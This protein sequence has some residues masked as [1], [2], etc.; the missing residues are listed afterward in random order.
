M[1]DR[2]GTISVRIDM[3]FKKTTFN[4]AQTK[5]VEDL[6]HM[7]W[8]K[9]GKKDTEYGL[10]YPGEPGNRRRPPT[11]MERDKQLRFYKVM[12]EVCTN[13]CIHLL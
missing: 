2:A 9:E 10:F 3:G 12:D 7:I 11:W 1:Q 4:I 5:F 8:D 13:S 6:L